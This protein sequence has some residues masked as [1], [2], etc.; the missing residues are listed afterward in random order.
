MYL[1]GYEGSNPSLSA[2]D[3]P[4]RR[5]A[6]AD[7]P[8]ICARAPRSAQM[9]EVDIGPGHLDQLL[10]YSIR[11]S[12]ASTTRAGAAPLVSPHDLQV[13]A[14]QKGISGDDSQPLELGL[15]DEHAIKGIGVVPR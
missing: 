9:G 14:R 3:A 2:V 6:R 4:T 15:S 11:D 8:Q 5:A 13:I 10:A 7:L 12:C 1:Q